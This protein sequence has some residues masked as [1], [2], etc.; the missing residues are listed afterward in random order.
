MR[1]GDLATLDK[2]GYCRIVGRSKDVIIRGGENIFP[3]EV[4]DCLRQHP[5]ILDVEVRVS[6]LLLLASISVI[7][8][9]LCC[10]NYAIMCLVAAIFSQ[11]RSKVVGVPDEIY[12]EE[13][14]AVIKLHPSV[15]H[16]IG[17]GDVAEFSK[18]RMAK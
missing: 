14:G 18:P 7:A 1:T 2:D 3:K 5:D 13:V 11:P 10:H 12:G 9:C 8:A 17:V 15:Q 16:Q 4:E 6:R